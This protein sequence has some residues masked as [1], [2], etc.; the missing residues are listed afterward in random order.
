LLPSDKALF[1]FF[2]LLPFVDAAV[3]MDHEEGCLSVV[4]MFFLDNLAD[5]ITGMTVYDCPAGGLW[6]WD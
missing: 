3:I 4:T 1:P 5:M 2:P 6:V